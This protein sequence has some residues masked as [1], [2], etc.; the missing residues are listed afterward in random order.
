M[1]DKLRGWG[2]TGK[3]EMGDELNK[4]YPMYASILNK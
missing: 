4:N 2:V 3:E 1:K